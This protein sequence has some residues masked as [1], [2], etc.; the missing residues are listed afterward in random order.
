MIHIWFAIKWFH[1]VAHINT[2]IYLCDSK[3]LLR[4]YLWWLFAIVHLNARTHTGTHTVSVR[5]HTIPH[6]IVMDSKFSYAYLHLCWLLGVKHAECFCIA[7]KMIIWKEWWL[8][9]IFVQKM[10]SNTICFQK[11]LRLLCLTIEFIGIPWTQQ[12][13]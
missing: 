11:N 4:A 13:K 9:C 1:L 12:S 2:S 10:S 5:K 3:F 6:F 8:L 7:N